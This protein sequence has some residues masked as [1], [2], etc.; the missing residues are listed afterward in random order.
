MTDPEAQRRLAELAIQ[1]PDDHGYELQQGLMRYRVSIWL[2]ANSA[3][4]TKLISAFHASAIGGHSGIRATYQRLKRLFAWSRLKTAVTKFVQQCDICQHAKHLNQHPQGLLQPLPIPVGS[5]QNITMDF[6]EGL[7]ISEG[8][9]TILVMVDSFTK[10]VH[11]IPLRHPFTAPQVG[12]VFVDYI[13]KLH[14]MP[15][16]IV[17]DRDRILTSLF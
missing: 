11:F 8:A 4:Q 1:S 15:K 16:S 5:W 6:I 13:V 17:S 7:P 14:G 3:L 12:R 10:Y 2:G 9:N